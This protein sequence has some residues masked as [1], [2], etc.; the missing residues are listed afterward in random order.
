M[1]RKSLA[2]R[3]TALSGIWIM[4]TLV[5]TAV[6]LVILYRDHIAQHFDAHV[7]MHV[8]ELVAASVLSPEG[9]LSLTSY[10][11]DPRFQELNSG[12][13]WEVRQN[14][15]TLD[16]SSSLGDERLD[17]EGLP[18]SEWPLVHEIM[19]PGLEKL[20]VQV[21]D[22][23]LTP[24]G[25]SLIFLAS[26]PVKSIMEDV[27]DFGWHVLSSFLILGFGLLTAVVVQVKIALR[28][29]HAISAGIS[30]IRD[31]ISQKLDE[32]YPS[33][34]QPVVDA[35]NNLL[36]HNAV[37]LKRARNQLGDLAHSIKNPLTVLNN[38]AR[39]MEPGQKHLLLQQT[40]DIERSV[41]HYLSRARAFGTESILGAKSNVKALTEDL[42]FVM[43]QIYQER[44]LQIDTS[45]VGNC[46]CVF[47]GESQDLEEMLGNLLDN[48][49]KWARTRVIVHCTTRSKRLLLFVEDDGSGM[50]ESQIEQAMQRGS[51]LDDSRPGHGLGL[52]I[53]KDLAEL[54]DGKMTI[55]GSGYGGVCAELDLPGA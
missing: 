1:L 53:V 38:E 27:Q 45:G 13:Y 25:A 11:T 18:A 30:R 10:P 23:A 28:P 5:T 4:M 14:G 12:W 42:V 2:F 50:D 36:E 35:L 44:E 32:S 3:I 16:R 41:E 40:G 20:R 8:E 21:V 19:G 33:D 34:V 39:N 51:K 49:C 29:L 54:Y 22:M 48:A 6:L 24:T 15:K 43:N 52:G 47:R 7:F 9:E 37:L 17:L 31:G 26:A 46:N 55:S